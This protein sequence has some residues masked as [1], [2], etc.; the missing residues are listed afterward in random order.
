MDN[1]NH[2]H[3]QI[4]TEGICWLTLT[5]VDTS[6]NTLSRQVLL[7]LDSELDVLEH[8]DEIRGL[9]IQ[10][11]KSGFIVGA[12]IREFESFADAQ[13]AFDAVRTAQA[14]FDRLEALPVPSI[15]L[16]NGHA[17]GGGLELA[18]ACRHRI[19]AATNDKTLGLPEVQLG[20]HP[21][22]GGTVRSIAL[23]G[24]PAAL[25]L[26]LS[27]RSIRPDRA[28]QLGLL[29]DVV[30]ADQLQQRA[31]QLIQT[32]PPPR[33]AVW[34]LRCLTLLGVRQVLS[35]WIR[36]QVRRRVNPRHYPAPYAI[37]DLFARHGG[38]GQKA[39]LAEARSIAE[40]VVTPTCRNLV[41]VFFLR[42]RLKDSA[43]EAS[44]AQHLHVVGAGLMG[45]DIAAWAA[46]QGFT[47]SLQDRAAE[48]VE[49]ALAR[50]GKF[51]VRRF[52]GGDELRQANER[53]S[54]DLDADRVAKADVVIEA[55]FENLEA[56]QKLFQQLE[57][58]LKSGAILASNTSSIRLELIAEGLQD[59]SRLVGIHFFNPVA[60]LPLVEV[61]RGEQ[62]DPEVFQQAL[63]FVIKLGKLPLPC[64]SAPGFLVNR[65]LAPYMLEAMLAHQEGI[66][67]ETIDA[68]AEAFGMP[69]GPVELADR[70]GLDVAQHVASILGEALGRPVPEGLANMVAAGRLG[71]KSGVGFYRYA[72]NRAQKRSNFAKAPA[73][74]EDRLILPMVN[75]AVACHADRVV[76]ELDLVDAGVIFGTGFAPFT[77]GP[78][79]YA[80]QR[81]I[82][83]V[84]ARLEELA[85]RYGARFKPHRAW[86]ALA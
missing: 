41:R 20:V 31:R 29:D 61:I 28:H 13:H 35:Y 75:E 36:K 58:D 26:M 24:A 16:I 56:K 48:Y 46:A 53:L 42:E 39:M 6:A 83:S 17:L 38:R 43:R 5:R 4:D 37:I 44:R 40:L 80:R 64:R 45:G 10:S 12:D 79:Q 22:F 11:G 76:S 59:P 57:P 3:Q 67:L 2:W 23:A 51:F 49:R 19:A 84:R 54:M 52:K 25:D 30:P 50:A 66:D 71:A 68:T 69:V 1:S 60:K 62:T 47:V 72:N 73:D 8:N 85:D 21:G 32:Q 74:L 18:M 81:G 15:A 7:Q 14:I 63:R 55:I 27:G 9:V 78:V 86:Q 65:I 34:Y 33:R 77:G 82:G 70:V